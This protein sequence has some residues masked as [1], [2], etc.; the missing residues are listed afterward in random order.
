MSRKFTLKKRRSNWMRIL[1]LRRLLWWNGCLLSEWELDA[2]KYRFISQ[3]F[4]LKKEDTRKLKSP[5]RAQ[6]RA[7]AKSFHVYFKKQNI[8]LACICCLDIPLSECVWT[9]WR[10]RRVSLTRHLVQSNVCLFFLWVLWTLQKVMRVTQGFQFK[11]RWIEEFSWKSRVKHVILYSLS[12]LNDKNNS[13]GLIHYS[14]CVDS[15]GLIWTVSR[16][17]CS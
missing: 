11:R 2:A 8:F 6:N 9:R 16:P 4:K 17:K 13:T 14:G 12:V 7:T 5:Q 10:H 15:V 1:A 3:N